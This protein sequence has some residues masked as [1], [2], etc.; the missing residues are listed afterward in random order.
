MEN[1][2]EFFMAVEFGDTEKV[3]FSLKKGQDINSRNIY[4]ESALNI[5]VENRQ[6]EVFKI[7][8]DEKDINL[9]NQGYLTGTPLTFAIFNEQHEMI[10]DLLE[11][12]NKFEN[13]KHPGAI[14][15]AVINDFRELLS[16][17]KSKGADFNLS[18]LEGYSEP[19]DW[20]LKPEPDPK[21]TPFHREVLLLLRHTP[22][23]LAIHSEDLELLKYLLENLE[24]D[25]NKPNCDN[26]LPLQMATEMNQI[27]T[28][29]ILLEYGA[30]PELPIVEFQDNK[31]LPSF[32]HKRMYNISPL[33]QKLLTEAKQKK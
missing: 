4:N 33:I 28:V 18:G 3:K 14:I 22:L 12:E 20:V 13:K 24:V 17:L 1:N 10:N 23:C 26:K 6:T 11:R 15:W 27:E 31:D 7:L 21:S 5:A 8:L 25:P 19:P 2:T 29:K 16:T 9:H 32:L 30:N